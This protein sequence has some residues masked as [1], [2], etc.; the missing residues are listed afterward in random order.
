MGKRGGA[1]VVKKKIALGDDTDIKDLNKLFSQM[2]GATDADRDILVPKITKVYTLLTK[3]NSIFT[4]LLNFKQFT[5]LFTEYNFWFDEIKKFLQ[6]MKESTSYEKFSNSEMVD[7]EC[8]KLEDK[9][10]NVFYKTLKENAH[11]KKIIVTGGNL[12]TYKKY[13]TDANNIDDVFIKR[14]PGITLQPLSFSSLDLKLI[15]SFDNVGDKARKFILSIIRHTYNISME[16]Y[17]VITSPDVDIKKMSNM[18]VS[19]IG[20]LK[21]QLPRCEHAFGI[22]ENS[23]DLLEN[24]FKTY[25]RHSVES[26]NPNIII[27]SFIVDISTSQK[28]SPILA[29]EFKKIVNFLKEKSGQINDPKIKKLFEILNNQFSGIEKN[30]VPQPEESQETLIL[31]STPKPIVETKSESSS[32]EIELLLKALNVSK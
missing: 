7:T 12:T 2:L 22:L 29:G 9:D 32:P 14:E 5:E 10:L 25:F 21:K 11:I 19:S 8:G 24:N 13:L 17:E 20:Q 27:E 16:M 1:K 31:E 30:V 26:N 15:W 18:L 23:V 4:T 3:Y 28:A 6:D